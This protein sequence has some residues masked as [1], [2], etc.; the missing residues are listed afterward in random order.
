MSPPTEAEAAAKQKAQKVGWGCA[1]LL[2][3]VMFGPCVAISQCPE[4]SGPTCGR[5]YAAKEAAEEHREAVERNPF[6]SS[7][8]LAT[9]RS[10]EEVADREWR[11]CIGR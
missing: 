9:A 10:L 11:A 6:A 1:G 3:L 7:G 4:S 8:D 5:Q 2:A